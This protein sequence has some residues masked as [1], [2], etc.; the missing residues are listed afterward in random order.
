MWRRN[1]SQA[2]W[3]QLQNF[4]RYRGE[5]R[6]RRFVIFCQILSEIFIFKLQ[7]SFSVN[8]YHFAVDQFDNTQC[9]GDL[10]NRKPTFGSK[11]MC[12]HRPRP[13]CQHILATPIK[14]SLAVTVWR[15]QVQLNRIPVLPSTSPIARMRRFTNR[16][17][18][19]WCRT[20]CAAYNPETTPSRRSPDQAAQQ[21]KISRQLETY[22][23]S[24]TKTKLMELI[25]WKL[26]DVRFLANNQSPI[27]IFWF[28]PVTNYNSSMKYEWRHFNL[29]AWA[30][31][32][33][34]RKRL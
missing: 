19:S 28:I 34:E 8:R 33:M 26:L 3:S 11:T 9:S 10:F 5:P 7:L 18:F 1:A 25:R 13:I 15:E 23:M 4:L 16:K 29:N 2:Q 12:A 6:R 24:R 20:V 22:A 21:E 27:T 32:S 31:V 14:I 30:L 17:I